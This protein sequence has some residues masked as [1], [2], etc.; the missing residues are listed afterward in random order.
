MKMNQ[1]NYN[2][3]KGII[4]LTKRISGGSMVNEDSNNRVHS[5]D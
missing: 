5:H 1:P 3:Y 4:Q 2:K